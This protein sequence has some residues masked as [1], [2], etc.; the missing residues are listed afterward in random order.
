MEYTLAIQDVFGSH[1]ILIPTRDGKAETAAQVFQERWVCQFG[2]PLMV[3]SDRC[4]YFTALVFKESRTSLGN[5]S[6]LSSANH[7][8]SQGQVE[9]QNQ[10]VENIRCVIHEELFSW[11][12]AV[13]GVQLADNTAV[14]ATT[15]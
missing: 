15:G 13:N 7:P 1:C 11:P 3:Q 5:K 9:R 4:T 6:K 10:L 8:Q 14:N 12:R 2:I